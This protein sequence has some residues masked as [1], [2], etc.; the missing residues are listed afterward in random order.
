MF[1]EMFRTAARSFKPGRRLEEVI[2]RTS[3]ALIRQAEAAAAPPAG[4]P[5]MPPAMPPPGDGG[6]P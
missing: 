3:E 4:P 6:A 5:A 1:L 2:A